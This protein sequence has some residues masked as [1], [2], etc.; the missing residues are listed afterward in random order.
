MYMKKNKKEWERRGITEY[1]YYNLLNMLYLGL[2]L[3]I[4]E[5]FIKKDT[6]KILAPLHK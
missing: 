6:R 5:F 4:I 2:K 3:E 1:E